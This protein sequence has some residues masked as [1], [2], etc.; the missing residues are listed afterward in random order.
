MQGLWQRFVQSLT[1]GVRWL[2]G[3]W[4]LLYLLAVVLSSLHVA[5]VFGWLMLTGSQMLHGQ[6]WRLAGY[7]LLPGTLW[8]L[9][10]CGMLLVMFGGALERVWTPRDLLIYGLVCA[11]GAG[12]VKTALQPG[13]SLPLLGPG[14]MVFALM[15]ACARLFPHQTMMLP[16]S[17][18]LTMRQ[19]V[20]LLAAVTFLATARFSGW[21]SALITVSGGGCG[22]A[23]LWLRSRSAQ[24]RKAG[25][26]VSRRINRLEL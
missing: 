14:P 20:M 15:V 8:E 17:I 16:P 6:V 22:L 18:E 10:V 2:L 3:T 19:L 25:P 12:L 11:A 13:P 5:D 1:P 26:V 23:Y 4:T 9:V 24:S 7:A 21:I